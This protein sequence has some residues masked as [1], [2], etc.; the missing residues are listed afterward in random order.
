MSIQLGQPLRELRR[1]DGRTQGELAL[2]CGVNSQSN[3]RWA[4]WGE[5]T[6]KLGR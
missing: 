5:K 4:E 1:R 6:Q 3:L 2:T